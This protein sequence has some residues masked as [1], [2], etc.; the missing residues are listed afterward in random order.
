MILAGILLP[1][2][3]GTTMVTDDSAGVDE[4]GLP[5]ATKTFTDLEAPGTKFGTLTIQEWETEIRKRFPEGEVQHFANTANLYAALD[6]GIIDAAFGFI[7]ERET[8][9]GTHPNLAY[10]TEPFAA[11]DFGFGTQKGE[12]GR[13]ILGELNLYLTELKQ[14]GEY[15]KLRQKWED[16][17]REGDVMGEYS[18]TGEKGTLR[19]ATGGLWTPMTFFEGE[20]LTGEFIEIIKG[21]C[22]SAGY[23]P[24]FEVVSFSAEIAGLAAGTYDIVADSIVTTDERKESISITDP[25]MKDEYYLLVRR[26]PV[27]KEVPK[28]SLFIENLKGSIQRNFI[29]ED[30]YRI[31][32]SGLGVTLS[33]SLAAGVFGT[34]LGAF[35]CFL[36]MRKNPFIHAFAAL[37]IRIFRAL[38]VVVLLLVFY[39]I[40][41][42]NSGLSAFKIC[43]ITFSIEFSAYCAEI[44]RSGINTVPDGQYKAA[45]ALGFGK[46]RSFL[47]VIWPQAMV[48]ILPVYSGQFISTVK[49]TAVAGYIS[50][51]DLTKASDIILARTYDAFFPLFFTAFVYFLICWLLVNML[52]FLEKR[53]DPSA[54][55]VSGDI[56]AVVNAFDPEHAEDYSVGNNYRT[57]QD[58]TPLIRVEHLRKSFENVTPVKDVSFDISRGDVISIIGPSGTGKSTLL[59][60]INHLLEPDGGRIFFDGQDTLE[61]GYDFN[62]MR[63]QIG[64]VFQS[65]NLFPH[66]TIIENLMLA[67]T[68][69]LKRSRRDACERSMKLL[70]MVGLTDKA[71]SLPSQLSGGQQQ[72]VAI[73][74]AVAMDPKIILFDEPTSA[75]DPTMVGE[76]LA[77]I[78]MLVKGGMTMVIVTHE[79]RFA[80]DVSNRVLF[81]DEGAIYEEGTPDEIFND[82]KRQKTRQFINRLKVFETKIPKSGFDLLNLITRIEQFGFRNM[83]SRQLVYRMVTVA[84]ELCIQ[85]ILPGLNSSEKIGLVFEYNEENGTSISMEVTYPSKDQ[86]SLEEADPLSRK[87]IENAC[88]DLS[89]QCS[90]GFCTVKGSIE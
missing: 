87:L 43:A 15:D 18:F 31:I 38:P 22:S 61:K 29:T 79:M 35:I 10:I 51:V 90:G 66:L 33:L 57:D 1:Q 72:R 4:N 41:F 42:R 16:P 76:V 19:V 39:Y 13:V 71:L 53:I 73:I 82:P 74:R 89:Y 80:K 34:I 83:I 7:D 8:V 14:S 37:Y 67:Q 46:L 88:H 77:A 59:Y 50:V 81:I 2:L 17:A 11:I 25:L 9:A 24:Q 45:A 48:H 86:D 58:N 69:L 49:M 20:T 5:I 75:L 65:F 44:F 68:E 63:E 6:A 3:I 40:V 70:N 30:R 84:E 36:H 47:K 55:S 21:F 28:A 64:M 26:E 52:R 78:R 27:L 85:T 23:I 60:L 54:R 12:S 56:L 32:L 62:R